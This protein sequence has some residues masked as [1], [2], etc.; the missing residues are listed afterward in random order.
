MAV[1]S[2]V[3]T[4][5]SGLSTL[6]IEDV[7]E[8]S[9]MAMVRARTRDVAVPAPAVPDE[10]SVRQASGWI[11]RK[12]ANLAPEEQRQLAQ[13]LARCPELDALHQC[14]RAFADMVDDHNGAGFSAWIEQ[15]EALELAPLH[16]F[17]RGLR[18]DYDAVAAEISMLWNSGPSKPTSTASR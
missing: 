8:G 13:I 12:P 15:A 2:L 4:V 1:A 17:A 11:I 5:F 18:Q 7:S 10:P 6:V 14:V 16:K 9:G 3:G